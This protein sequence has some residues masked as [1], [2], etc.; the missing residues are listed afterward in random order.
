MDF[1]VTLAAPDNFLALT[2]EYLQDL[3]SSNADK[4]TRTIV[5]HNALEP[6]NPTRA[7]RYFSNARIIVIDRDPR[8]SF[9]AMKPHRHLAVSVD[10]FILR[11]RVFREE[12]A[13]HP[14]DSR[15]VLRLKFE[16][17]LFDYGATVARVLNFLE[18]DS[19]V[20]VSPGQYFNPDISRRN[21]GIWR[22]H[23]DQG[24]IQK[25]KNALGRWCD[26]R[27]D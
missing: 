25:I 4:T 2:R 8:D 11:F 3:L 16:D 15:Q 23:P 14:E 10:D 24:E 21:A 26:E 22:Q 5:T 9:V 19:S 12:A 1:T 6:F 20:H 18:E 17:L 27:N 7:L 13:R